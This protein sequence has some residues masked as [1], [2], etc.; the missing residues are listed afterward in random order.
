M[1]RGYTKLAL[2]MQYE[3]SYPLRVLIDLVYT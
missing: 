2:N 3:L 1:I